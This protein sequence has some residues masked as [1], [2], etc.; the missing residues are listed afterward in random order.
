MRTKLFCTFF[1]NVQKFLEEK[2]QLNVATVAT[3][4]AQNIATFAPFKAQNIATFALF[5]AQNI[6]TFAPF[7]AQNIAIFAPFM[8]QNIAALKMHC[9]AIESILPPECCS[10]PYGE[11]HL[12]PPTEKFCTGFN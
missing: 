9:S 7:K 4:K 6:A 1:T 10:P 2:G 12:P 5:K 8:A 3:L 11:D